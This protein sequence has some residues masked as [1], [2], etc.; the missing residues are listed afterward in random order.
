MQGGIYSLDLDSLLPEQQL[1]RA[2]GADQS[3]FFNYDMNEDSYREY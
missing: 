2:A 1:W 3:Q